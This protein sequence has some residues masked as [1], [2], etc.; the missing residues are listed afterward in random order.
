MILKWARHTVAALNRVLIR[1]NRR[2]PTKPN[3]GVRSRRHS[4]SRRLRN[5]G[6]TLCTDDGAMMAMMTI[7]ITNPPNSELSAEWPIASLEERHMD[8]VEQATNNSCLHDCLR[9]CD[10][11]RNVLGLFT[12]YSEARGFFPCRWP[13]ARVPCQSMSRA[14]NAGTADL[15]RRDFI[16]KPSRSLVTSKS[17]I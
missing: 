9:E 16:A 14:V 17:P 10:G 6:A 12:A 3:A 5:A 13:M 4:E 1:T 11:L 8:W 15:H 2:R 7:A